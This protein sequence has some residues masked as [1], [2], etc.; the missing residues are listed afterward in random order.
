VGKVAD[1]YFQVD[2]WR[3]IETDF[4]PS[5]PRRGVDLLAR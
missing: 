2:P 1:R 5:M 3:I 4:A